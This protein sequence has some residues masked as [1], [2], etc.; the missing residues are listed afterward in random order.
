MQEW[1]RFNLAGVYTEILQEWIRFNLAGVYTEILPGGNLGYG[2]KGE[3]RVWTKEGGG[4]GS[5]SSMVSC[6]VLH[7]WQLGGGGGNAQ[8]TRD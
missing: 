4:G 6:E 8:H 2:Q 3:F 5:R 1:I 7:S